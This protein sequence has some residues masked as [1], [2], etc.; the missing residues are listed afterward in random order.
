M[1]AARG[2]DAQRAALIDPPRDTAPG[3]LRR[4]DRDSPAAQ[5]VSGSPFLEERPHTLVA[6]PDEAIDDLGREPRG[7]RIAPQWIGSCNSCV[8]VYA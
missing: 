7:Q 1:Q 2:F 4:P 8:Y 3:V 5:R 6:E